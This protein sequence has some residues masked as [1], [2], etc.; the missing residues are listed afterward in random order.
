MK[1]ARLPQG[2]TLTF[3]VESSSPVKA[4]RSQFCGRLAKSV[5]PTGRNFDPH[6][7]VR[8]VLVSHA[9]RP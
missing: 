8:K 4:V 1:L 7:L 6:F 9:Q 3:R 2:P 5:A